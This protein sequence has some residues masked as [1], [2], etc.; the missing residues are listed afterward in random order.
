MG[1]LTQSPHGWYGG[2]RGN[3]VL[4]QS[5]FFVHSGNTTRLSL[6][7]AEAAVITVLYVDGILNS[8]DI[9]FLFNI[10]NIDRKY[11]KDVIILGQKGEQQKGRKE[12]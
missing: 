4:D 3:A 8:P 12:G 5:T 7:N 2:G 9:S 11:G 10:I 1:F 6:P